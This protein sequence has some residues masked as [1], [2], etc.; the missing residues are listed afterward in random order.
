MP[1]IGEFAIPSDTEVICLSSNSES[2]ASYDGK[3]TV[4][5]TEE[6]GASNLPL[7]IVAV[8]II[9]I[10]ALLAVKTRRP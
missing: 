6:E 3:L 8:A 4:E 1:E 10:A 7:I 5:Q 2:W 9:I